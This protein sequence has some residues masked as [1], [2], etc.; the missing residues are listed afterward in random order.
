[1]KILR[2]MLF[3]LIEKLKH[4]TAILL[5]THRISIARSAKRIYILKTVKSNN[6]ATTPAF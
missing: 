4:N 5:L 2:G 1:M 3:K 6:W